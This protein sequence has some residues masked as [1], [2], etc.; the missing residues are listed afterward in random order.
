MPTVEYIIYVNVKATMQIH[1]SLTYSQ[2]I[3]NLLIYIRYVREK[4]KEKKNYWYSVG[5]NELR[6]ENRYR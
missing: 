3:R 4:K 5:S 2:N 1:G 6:N